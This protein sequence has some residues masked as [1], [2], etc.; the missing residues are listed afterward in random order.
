MLQ[1]I[2]FRQQEKG[3][4]AIFKTD[5]GSKRREIL[6]LFWTKCQEARNMVVV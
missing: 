6:P 2:S 1:K 3:H 5:L 4:T